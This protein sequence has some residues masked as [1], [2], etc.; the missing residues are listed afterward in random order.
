MQAFSSNTIQRD[1]VVPWSMAATRRLAAIGLL[2]RHFGEASELARMQP[3]PLLHFQLF[4]RAKADLQM[5]TD[6]LA[7]EFARHPGTL[8]LISAAR[9]VGTECVSTCRSR[10]AP[11]L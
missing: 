8:D 3:F 11:L 10:W 1:D 5:L 7:V 9:R 2:E 4:K 6:A